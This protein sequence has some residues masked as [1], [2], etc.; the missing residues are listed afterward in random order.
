MSKILDIWLAKFTFLQL[1]LQFVLVKSVKDFSQMSFVLFCI[2]IINEYMAQINQNEIINVTSH[3]AFIKYRWCIAQSK[4]KCSIFKQPMS[5][6]KRSF[7][8]S[9]VS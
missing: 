4:R 9:I 3:N 1:G 6:D 5:S 2:I 8:T 7:F